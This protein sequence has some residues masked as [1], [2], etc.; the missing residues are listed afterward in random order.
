MH[1]TTDNPKDQTRPEAA[2]SD[3]G[4]V[5]SD[6]SVEMLE[7]LV[8]EGEAAAYSA[9]THKTY[10]VGWRSWTRWAAEHDCRVFPADPAHLQMWIVTL[11]CQ[12]MKPST[13]HTYLAGIAFHHRGCDGA[14]PAH[15]PRVRLLL[16]GLTR[17]AAARG[18]TA[19][20]AAP[21]RWDDIQQIADSA[22]EPRRNQPGRRTETPDQARQRADI[23]VAMITVAHDAALRSS[24]LLALR[25]KDITFP[26]TGRCGLVTIRRS[27]TDQT[28]QGAVAPISEYASHAL[29]RLKP[30]DPHPDQRIFNVSPSTLNRRLKTAART[31]GINHVDISSHSPR[32]GMA[33]DLTAHGTTMAGLKQAG[34]WK[35]STTASRYTRHLTAHH[36]PACQYLKTQHRTEPSDP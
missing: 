4:G 29:A 36:T 22:Y 30:A 6:L 11:D 23:D 26:Q 34:R 7:R 16:R 21:L 33:Q 3:S 14:N 24:E 31:A 5:G 10:N 17:Q 13:W 32:I 15:D 20:Q 12:N 28:G 18:R 2:H 9:N 1:H 19:K 35:T 25:W 8:V 27:K